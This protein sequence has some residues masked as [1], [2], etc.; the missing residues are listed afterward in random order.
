MCLHTSML[1]DLFRLYYAKCE[2]IYNIQ[3]NL[4][5]MNNKAKLALKVRRIFFYS[6][7]A[8]SLTLFFIHFFD[9]IA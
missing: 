1:R 6:K 9:Y 4:T 7:R 8:V 2:Q 5:K 3:H